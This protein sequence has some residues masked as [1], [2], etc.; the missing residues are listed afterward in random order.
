MLY[1][2]A[3]NPLKLISDVPNRMYINMLINPFV[4]QKSHA[5]FLNRV[6]HTYKYILVAYNIRDKTGSPK[7]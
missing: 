2:I 7:F 1:F 6:Y 5:I 4:T 3:S